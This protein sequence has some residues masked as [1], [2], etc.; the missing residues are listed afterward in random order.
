MAS[1]TGLHWAV[2]D[3]TELYEAVL[4]CTGLL[5][6]VLECIGFYRAVLA[7][8]K[9]KK[10]RNEILRILLKQNA[11]LLSTFRQSVTG[12]TSQLFSIIW[13]FRAWKQY[14]FWKHIIQGG[15]PNHSY[16]LTTW[17]PGPPGPLGPPGPGPI[18][19][20]WKPRLIKI[21]QD[22]CRIRIADLIFF[23]QKFIGWCWPCPKS[24]YEINLLKLEM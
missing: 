17:P 21:Y 16:R 4:G 2:L 6:A 3:F 14:T 11:A 15:R 10:L 7:K 1:L 8:R 12:P 5:W 19:P 18:E 9:E 24:L 20:L 22:K 23:L 13:W